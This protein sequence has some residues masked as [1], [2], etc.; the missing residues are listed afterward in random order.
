MAMA[1]SKMLLFAAIFCQLAVS[2]SLEPS[3]KTITLNNGV[4][5]PT[6]AYGTW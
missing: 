4:V 2:H 5:M 1:T 3:P 6:V